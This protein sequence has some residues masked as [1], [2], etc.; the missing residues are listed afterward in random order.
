M[1]KKTKMIA[2]A[3]AASLC[4]SAFVGCS[5]AA[6]T[7]ETTEDVSSE[8]TA[9]SEPEVTELTNSSEATETTKAAETT[10]AHTTTTTAKPKTTTT[11]EWSGVTEVPPINGDDW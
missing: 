7:D 3:V 9:N 5:D 4:L 11:T 6:D 2:V 8:I 1:T 10:E